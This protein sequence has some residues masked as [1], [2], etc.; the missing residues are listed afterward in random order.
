MKLRDPPLNRPQLVGTAS[1]QLQHFAGVFA[2]PVQ[3]GSSAK[4]DFNVPDDVWK[5]V[6]PTKYWNKV[7]RVECFRNF[8]CERQI[9]L[10]RLH[11]SP[12]AT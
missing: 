3:C 9:E 7:V 1:I 2:S 5:T 11:R 10:F 4:Y 6:V 12:G 8:A